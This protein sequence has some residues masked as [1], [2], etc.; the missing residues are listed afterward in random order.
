MCTARVNVWRGS[1]RF[2]AEDVR[3]I[4]RDGEFTSSIFVKADRMGA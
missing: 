3:P 4:G 1:F 2:S